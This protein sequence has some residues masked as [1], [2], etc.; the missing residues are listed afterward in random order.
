MDVTFGG[1]LVLRKLLLRGY[2]VRVMLRDEQS[3][4]E[5][6]SSKVECIIGD[7]LDSQKC[8]EAMKGVDKVTSKS[9]RTQE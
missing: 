1:R 2:K 7:V 4:E 5:M 9:V 8:Q 3:V 6:L